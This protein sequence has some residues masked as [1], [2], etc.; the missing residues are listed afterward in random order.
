MIDTKTVKRIKSAPASER[1]QIMELILQSLKDEIKKEPPVRRKRF[2]VRK[3]N[4][5]REVHVDRDEL[6]SERS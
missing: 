3:F 1:I 6:Y 2:K 5:G 4:L